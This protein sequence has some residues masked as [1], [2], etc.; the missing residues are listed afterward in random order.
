MLSFE[1]LFE[2][3]YILKIN[4]K[5]HLLYI[6]VDSDDIFL[7]TFFRGLYIIYLINVCGEYI[8][9]KCQIKVIRNKL[10]KYAAPDSITRF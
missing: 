4:V 1:L 6:F 8:M 5:F 10:F 9:R 7:N 2:S 3:L